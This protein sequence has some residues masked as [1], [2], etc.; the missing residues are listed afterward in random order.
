MSFMESLG[1]NNIAIGEPKSMRNVKVIVG[2]VGNVVCWEPGIRLEGCTIELLGNNSLVYV[3]KMFQPFRAHIIIGNG[4]T[5]YI[6]ND[7]FFHPEQPIRINVDDNA[8]VCLGNDLL[9]SI[10]VN[11]D[12]AGDGNELNVGDHSWLCHGASVMGSSIIAPNT[13]V[14]SRALLRD[15]QTDSYSCWGGK[16]RLLQ[17]DVLFSKVG[18]RLLTRRQLK[19]REQLPTSEADAIQNI[20]GIDFASLVPRIREC[21]TPQERCECIATE[22]E[23]VRFKRMRNPKLSAAGRLESMQN[24]VAGLF[25]R[26][27]NLILGEFEDDNGDSR[28]MFSGTGN[29]MIVEPGVRLCG[30]LIKFRGNNGLLYLS[31]S[32]EPYRFVTTIHNDSTVFFG[33]NNQFAL[34]GNRVQISPA[35]GK[36]IVIGNRCRLEAGTWIRTS[37]QHAIYS[38]NTLKRINPAEPVVFAQDVV[39]GE[40]CVVQK[41][42]WADRCSILAHSLVLRDKKDHNDPYAE[43][44][45]K[46]SKT[47]SM[48]FRRHEAKRFANNNSYNSR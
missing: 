1:D 6:G 12:T 46:L 23:S 2:G 38:K 32:D 3:S 36:A 34:R 26:S 30:C 28:I 41:G 19:L 17:T 48:R 10:N 42:V 4:A 47:S 15:C 13:I 21:N 25:M 37:D 33:H 45:R 22:K 24:K 20:A 5:L 31:R 11:V 14:A 40:D 16:N 44:A 43:L 39:A 35:E 18:L 27:D 7:S 9:T 8:V 29:V